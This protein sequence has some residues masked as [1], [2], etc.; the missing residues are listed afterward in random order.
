MYSSYD[1]NN[2]PTY[3][4]LRDCIS[5]SN[6]Y[7]LLEYIFLQYKNAAFVKSLGKQLKR[8]FLYALIWYFLL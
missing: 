2:L 7:K 4:T 8:P 6:Q 3:N 5:L 1:T